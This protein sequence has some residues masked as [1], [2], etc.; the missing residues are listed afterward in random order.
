MEAIF[1]LFLVVIFTFLAYIAIDTLIRLC[2]K[3]K[4][5]DLVD[6]KYYDKIIYL[7]KKQN[8]YLKIKAIQQ[9]EY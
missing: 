2:N 3:Y 8:I 6:E 4:Q 9:N 7:G 5:N 1:A